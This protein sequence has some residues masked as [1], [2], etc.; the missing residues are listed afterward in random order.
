[1]AESPEKVSFTLTDTDE[2]TEFY[3]VGQT[4]I[5]DVDYILVTDSMEDGAEAMILKD[6]AAGK[7]Q[8]D[9]IYEVVEDDVE[10]DAISR[11]FAEIL[12]VID[13]R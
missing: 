3:V 12:D 8:E 9:S 11:V 10:L 6:T 7:G 4:K 2:T 13:L 5:G 1:M